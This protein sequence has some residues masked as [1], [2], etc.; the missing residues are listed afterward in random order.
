[1]FIQKQSGKNKVVNKKKKWK[2]EQED[3]MSH[4]EQEKSE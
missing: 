4:K 3:N 1:M 2:A